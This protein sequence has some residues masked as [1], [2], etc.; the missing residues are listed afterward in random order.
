MADI[1]CPRC[2]EPVDVEELHYVYVGDDRVSFEDAR[3]NFYRIGCAALSGDMQPSCN[4]RKTTRGEAA[5]VIYEMMGDDIDG[6]AALFDD[7][8]YLGLLD[9]VS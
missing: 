8:E 6:A 4:E 5:D 7:F 1:Y 9:G 3:S 2:D